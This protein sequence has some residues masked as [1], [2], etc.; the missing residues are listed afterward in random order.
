MMIID[1]RKSIFW[2]WVSFLPRKTKRKLDQGCFWSFHKILIIGPTFFIAQ[3]VL[4]LFSGTIKSITGGGN[5]SVTSRSK[6]YGKSFT[7][8]VDGAHFG[9]FF[10]RFLLSNLFSSPRRHC[11]LLHI[12]RLL[13]LRRR[14]GNLRCSSVT[15]P[16]NNRFRFTVYF[17]LHMA[18]RAFLPLDSSVFL[19]RL[20]RYCDAS[21]PREAEVW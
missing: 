20:Y 18:A 4:R 1:N 16:A 15:S 10:F 21:S 2:V 8:L 17:S 7:V 3:R 13:P 12:P 9:I 6:N 19:L 11:F 14:I 5:Q